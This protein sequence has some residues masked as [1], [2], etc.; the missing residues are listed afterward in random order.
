MPTKRKVVVLLSSMHYD[1]SVD[2]NADSKTYGKPE[3]ILFYDS[4]K[5]GVDTVDKYISH[6]SAIR[7]TNRWLM[8]VF[9]SL[10]NVGGLNGFIVFTKNTGNEGMK[11]LVF[12]QE[13]S[14]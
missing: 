14:R 11:R 4:S 9:Y 1:A 7:T 3:I 10:L 5:E 6:Y 8:V 2:E 13:L 12:L